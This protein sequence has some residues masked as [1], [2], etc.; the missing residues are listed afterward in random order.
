M[1]AAVNKDNTIQ[2][3][4]SP[5]Q[6]FRSN[7]SGAI[8]EAKSDLHDAANQV[9]RKVRGFIDTASDEISHTTDTVTKEIRSNPVQS[10]LIALGAGFI[11]GSLFRR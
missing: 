1:N 2:N 3:F 8:N 7:A 6:D 4:K 9:E 5:N 11:L 10:S